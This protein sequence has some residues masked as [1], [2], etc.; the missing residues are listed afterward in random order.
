MPRRKRT[1]PSVLDIKAAVRARDGRCV[2]CGVT[3]EQHLAQYGRQLDVHRVT[4]GS[5]YTVE[6]TVAVCRACHGPQPR[7]PRGSAD[8]GDGDPKM[9]LRIRSELYRRVAFAAET[10]GIKPSELIRQLIRK[11]LPDYESQAAAIRA[12]EIM[13]S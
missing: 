13:S 9:K 5:V 8:F 4:P 3:N 7:S 6:G 1:T 12:K 2:H 11:Q 10:L